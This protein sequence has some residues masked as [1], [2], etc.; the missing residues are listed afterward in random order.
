MTNP[1]HPRDPR[2]PAASRR[3]RT[4]AADPRYLI[5]TTDDGSLTLV[6][7]DSLDAFHSGA[8]AVSETRHVYLERS[9][10]AQRLAERQPTRVLEVGLGAGLGLLL[11]V[12]L[13]R[14]LATPIRYDAIEIDWPPPRVLEQLELGRTLHDPSLAEHFIRWRR[15]IPDPRSSGPHRWDVDPRTAAVVHIA[16]VRQWTPPPE[17][18]G[19][20]VSGYRGSGYD[21]IYFDPFSPASQPELWTEAIFETMRSLLAPDGRLVS[22][23][24]SRPVRDALTAAGFRVT[25]TPGPPGGKREV[26]VAELASTNEG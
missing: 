1:Q 16:D 14:H 13:A 25:R 7:A 9:S 4:V 12:D 8:G 18:G 21:A 10:V 24:V 20:D 19:F 22:Y 15:S 26:L 17:A 2:Q 6:T 23:C 11:T 5:E 3:P